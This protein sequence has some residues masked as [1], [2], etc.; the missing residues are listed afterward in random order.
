MSEESTLLG[1][2]PVV[3]PVV[4][5]TVEPVVEPVVPPAKAEDG[6]TDEVVDGAPDKYEDFILPDGV[7]LDEKM[8]GDFVPIAKELNLTQDQAQK[9]ISLQSGKMQ[10]ML[11]EQQQTWVK[12]QDDW[13]TAVK[14]DTELGGPAFDKTISDAKVFLKQ[15]AT[16]G[17]MEALDATGVGNHPEFIRAFARAGKLMGEDALALGGASE[18]VRNPEDVLYPNQSST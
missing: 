15:F 3:E 5:P 1:E 12:V 14:S 4:E 18:P 8:M 6:K 16:P 13:K 17:L 9:L 2:E 10:S 7:E 11:E